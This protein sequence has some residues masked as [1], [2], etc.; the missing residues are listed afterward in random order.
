MIRVYSLY[1][2]KYQTDITSLCK[3]VSISGDVSQCSRKMDLT[4]AYSLYDKN[5]PNVQIGCTNKIWMVDD[6][7]GEIFRGVVFDRELNSDNE[8]KIVV[9]DYLVYLLKSK[10][11][12][13]FQNMTPEDITKKACEE[14]GITPGNI[15][16]TGVKINLV[17]QNEDLYTIIMKAYTQASKITGIQYIPMMRGIVLD[18]I[19]K[20]QVVANYILNTKQN[21]T[22]SAYTDSLDNMINRVKIY[23]S[24]GNYIDEVKNSGW[25]DTC[26]VLQDSYTKEQDKNPYTVA[27]NMLHG[28]DNYFK[29]EALGNLKCKTGNA[30]N[31]TIPWFYLTTNGAVMYID[32]DV[33]TW[34]L[35]TG[36]YTM[37]LTL[38]FS[39]KMDLKEA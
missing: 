3:T 35:S 18:I 37:E 14:V 31:V 20:G 22:K 39:N 25:V 33:H 28:I 34:D 38:N 12:F 26:G 19:Q 23:D 4:V 11:S 24:N 16:S 6:V 30:V 21:I 32:T 29:I 7:E 36:K 27:Q 15:A 8:T 2:S 10:A 5:M 1:D 17:V 9:Y 13:N